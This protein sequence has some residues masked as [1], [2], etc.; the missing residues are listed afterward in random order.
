MAGNLKDILANLSPEVDQETLM[1]YLQKKLPADKQHEIE[2]KLLENEFAEDALEGL[3]QFSDERQIPAMVDQLNAD[4]RRKLEKKR[5][6]REKLR[7][8]EQP[9]LYI[10]AAIILMLIIIGYILVRKMLLQG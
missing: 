5:K 2:K 4:L 10:V 7:I 9:V 8:K 1:L 6:R 3:K